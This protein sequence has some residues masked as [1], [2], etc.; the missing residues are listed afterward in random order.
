MKKR[1]KGLFALTLV[2]CLFFGAMPG[3][4]SAEGQ[5]VKVWFTGWG[6][7]EQEYAT[8]E[9][10]EFQY[11]DKM[12]CEGNS[13]GGYFYVV[14]KNGNILAPKTQE[15]NT[16]ELYD[17]NGSPAGVR[18]YREEGTYTVPENDVGYKWKGEIKESDYKYWNSYYR[19]SLDSTPWEITLTQSPISYQITYHLNQ[20][21]GQTPESQDATY[22]QEIRLAD[23]SQIFRDGYTLKGWN[24]KSDGSG[25]SYQPGKNAKNL[26]TVEGQTVTLYAQ[27]ERSVTPADTGDKDAADKTKGETKSGKI[28]G[29]DSSPQ[30]GD[31]WHMAGYLLALIA[32]LVAMGGLLVRRRRT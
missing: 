22:D 25:E 15:E 32:S 9:P 27:W 11:G 16:E 28:S 20:G 29:S 26:T 8:K 14:D 12:V 13:S 17:S 6:I 30:T 7:S 3:V 4:V 24:T 19:P 5:E 31:D 23:G 10:L 1:I 21:S 2:F 18:A